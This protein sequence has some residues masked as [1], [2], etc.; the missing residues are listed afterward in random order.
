MNLLLRATKVIEGRFT[1]RGAGV[2]RGMS[3]AQPAAERERDHPA[4][5]CRKI[6]LPS[7][8]SRSLRLIRSTR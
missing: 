8:F 1:A 5:N 3:A 7:D 4:Q 6:Y 2:R